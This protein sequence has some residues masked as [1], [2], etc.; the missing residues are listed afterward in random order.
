MIAGITLRTELTLSTL[1]L[2]DVTHSLV[3][4]Y[5]VNIKVDN[6]KE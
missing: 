4:N 5:P 1:P 2:Q 3:N 6:V